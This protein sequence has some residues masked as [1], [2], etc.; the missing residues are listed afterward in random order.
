MKT[1]RD[2]LLDIFDSALAS[3][4]GK[5]V[6]EKEIENSKYPDEFHVIAIGKAA[7]SMLQGISQDR[8]KTALVISK[9][10]HIC[11][12]TQHHPRITSIE[13]DHPVPRENSLKSGELLLDYLKHLPND[14]PCLFLISGGASALVEVLED[15]WDLAQLQALTDYLLANAYPINEINAIR[16]RL[17]KIK[18]GGLWQFIKSQS[19]YALL[20]S[21]VP[22]DDPAVIGSGLLFPVSDSELPALPEEWKSKFKPYSIKAQGDNFHWKIIASLGIAKQAAA[23]KA[24]ELG[25]RTKI[26]AEFLDGEAAT[27]AATCMHAIEKEPDTLL[28][29]GGET[30]VNLPVNAGRGGRN[31]HLALAAAIQMQGMEKSYLLAAGTDGTDG[32]T[33]ATGALVDN[34]TIKKGLQKHLNAV[35]FL[36]RADSNTFLE[37]VDATI[38]TGATGTNVMDLV[39]AIY[40][41]V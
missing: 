11:E 17:S 27:V 20:I 28:V 40:R 33:D 24:K 15:G 8:I 21:D 13:S 29:W 34:Q 5:A 1:I 6:V 25:Y 41:P 36:Q 10:G 18:G 32:L 7:D 19:I 2:D 30:T 4:K 22:D 14:E 23:D 26:I 38:I 9:H 35:E 31:Q 12:K 37:M 16:R 3:V 39:I